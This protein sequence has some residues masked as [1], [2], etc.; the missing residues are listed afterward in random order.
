MRYVKECAARVPDRYELSAHHS[1][2]WQTK[3]M[4]RGLQRVSLLLVFRCWDTSALCATRVGPR[5]GQH[6]LQ[7]TGSTSCCALPPPPTLNSRDVLLLASTSS[8][9]FRT[10]PAH[11]KCCC[12]CT[13]LVWYQHT[14]VCS[15]TA[16]LQ[17]N[18][19]ARYTIIVVPSFLAPA[20]I[21]CPLLFILVSPSL[22]LCCTALAPHSPPRHPQAAARLGRATPAHRHATAL[23][24]IR[25]HTA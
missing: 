8:Q 4:A 2:K 18:N 16:P 12:V 25:R 15:Q 9:A 20:P 1:H 17:N 6:P 19:I 13:L 23:R 21:S 5:N 3:C 7:N 22:P 11:T 14:S 24:C 10:G